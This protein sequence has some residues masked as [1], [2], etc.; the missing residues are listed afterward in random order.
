LHFAAEQWFDL[1]RPHQLVEK[2][3]HHILADEPFP[4]LCEFGGMPD[5]ITRAE[6]YKAANQK[7][8]VQFH[9]VQAPGAGPV[10]ACSREAKSSFSGGHRGPALPSEVQLKDAMELSKG[11]ISQSADTAQGM[12]G[13]YS[14][15]NGDVGEQSSAALLLPSHQIRVR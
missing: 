5:Q 12:I 15:L 11:L 9:Q 14:L 1:C 7:V 2:G 8:V 3:T 10:E 4:A 13:Q 6:A